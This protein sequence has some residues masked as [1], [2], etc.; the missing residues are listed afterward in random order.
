MK[1]ETLTFERASRIMG[2]LGLFCTSDGVEGLARRQLISYAS[3]AE[4]DYSYST[5]PKRVDTLSFV[6][7]LVNYKN[8]P[9]EE[10]SKAI[11]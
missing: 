7:Y 10:I 2:K 11:E 1:Q 3:R 8:I 6:S 5:Y 9:S 4:D